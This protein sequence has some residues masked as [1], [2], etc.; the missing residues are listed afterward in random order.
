MERFVIVFCCGSMKDW[1]GLVDRP[2]DE[3][4]DVGAN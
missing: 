4:R 1:E 3:H 2:D